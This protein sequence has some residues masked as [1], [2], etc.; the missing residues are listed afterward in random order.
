MPYRYTVG[1]LLFSQCMQQILVVQCTRRE[2]QHVHTLRVNSQEYSQVCSRDN[3]YTVSQYRVIRY[4]I[5][6]TASPTPRVS[7]AQVSSP[8]TA[9]VTTLGA[10]LGGTRR[11]YNRVY[12]GYTSVLLG[13]ERTEAYAYVHVLATIRY[14]IELLLLALNRSSAVE[15]AA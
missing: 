13:V 2:T 6:Y 9:L 15:I 5:T 7:Q 8:L 12:K 10:V 14:R 4:G 1:H 11:W 3:S